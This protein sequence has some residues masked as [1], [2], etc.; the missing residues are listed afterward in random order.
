[1]GRA[2]DRMQPLEI[3]VGVDLGRGD[4]LVSQQFLHLPQVRAIIEQVGG[5]GVPQRMGRNILGQVRG[6]EVFL[7]E[8]PYRSRGKP[9]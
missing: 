3:E 6:D 9:P 4:P 2:V 5:E 7:E 1:M 8:S